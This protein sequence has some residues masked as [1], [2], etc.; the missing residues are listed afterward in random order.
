[1]KDQQSQEVVMDRVTTELDR[2]YGID[3]A[4]IEKIAMRASQEM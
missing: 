1:M 4:N 2:R 3:P